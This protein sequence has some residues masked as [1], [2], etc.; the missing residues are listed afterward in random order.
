MYRNKIY[1]VHEVVIILRRHTNHSK[2]NLLYIIEGSHM[3]SEIK[4]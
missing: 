1:L 4:T 2:N 3:K